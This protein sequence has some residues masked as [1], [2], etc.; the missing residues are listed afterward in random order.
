MALRCDNVD[1]G[2]E[3][4]LCISRRWVEGGS[5]PMIHSHNSSTAIIS[6]ETLLKCHFKA[7]QTFILPPQPLAHNSLARVTADMNTIS[8]LT[9][10]S[11]SLGGLSLFT[12]NKILFLYVDFSPSS[13]EM[14]TRN[15]A[16]RRAP[17]RRV[18]V[19][20]TTN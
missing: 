12:S 10:N 15:F 6:R 5:E 16:C 1:G 19:V 3:I 13:I 4:R 14:A 11:F 7:T 9:M 8:T 20:E 2:S 18:G 17:A